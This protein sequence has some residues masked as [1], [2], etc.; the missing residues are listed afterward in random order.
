MQE[1]EEFNLLLSLAFGFIIFLFF[2][3]VSLIFW[4]LQ[5]LSIIQITEKY[6]LLSVMKDAVLSLAGVFVFLAILSIALFIFQIIYSFF[7]NLVRSI[8]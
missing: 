2:A 8:L 3:V 1:P 6:Y 7:S 4:L 5:R